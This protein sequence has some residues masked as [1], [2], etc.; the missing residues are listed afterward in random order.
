ME[1]LNYQLFEI[2]LDIDGVLGANWQLLSAVP[3][4][5]IKPTSASTANHP[6]NHGTANEMKA[7]LHSKDFQPYTMIWNRPPH[8]AIRIRHIQTFPESTA[9]F[10]Y[11]AC[12]LRR[13]PA[14]EVP[15]PHLDHSQF[16]STLKKVP[17]QRW[18][19]DQLFQS[20]QINHNHKDALLED[21]KNGAWN[22]IWHRIYRQ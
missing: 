6:K 8:L 5:Y 2:L 13:T 14:Q 16:H 15:F 20:I 10:R 1:I 11:C 4:K 18:R 22:V 9:H 17:S 3:S 7:N 21:R 19:R 12:L